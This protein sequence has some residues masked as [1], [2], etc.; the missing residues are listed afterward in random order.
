MSI[1]EKAERFAKLHVKGQPLLL[2]NAWDAGSAKAIAAANAPAIA[3]SSWAVAA[4]H[5]YEDGEIL[6]IGLSETVIARIAASVDLP[7]T[8]DIEGGYA[9]D[10]DKLAENAARFLD[11]GVIG[12][13]FEDRVIAGTGLYEVSRQVGRI[14]AIRKMADARGLPLFLN[15]RTDLFLNARQDHG[16]LMEEAKRRVHAYAAAGAT[17][18]FVPGLKDAAHIAAICAESP[19]PV[20]V[21]M[22]PG[23]PPAHE[24]AA[25][26]VARVSFGP[27]PYIEAM[28][29]LSASARMAMQGSGLAGK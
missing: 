6:P 14:A 8:A 25:L 3:T 23:V 24:L 27:V 2:F 17:G 9:E 20:N 28:A 15:A 19:L 16:T 7:V 21:M 10:D 1:K 12:F 22:M 5:G 11:L 18:F 13:N 4:A 29:G 26:G